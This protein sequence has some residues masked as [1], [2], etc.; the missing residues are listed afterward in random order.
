MSEVESFTQITTHSF[1]V[2]GDAATALSGISASLCIISDVS[3]TKFLFQKKDN[4]YPI[5]EIRGRISMFGG[6]PEKGE[7]LLRA[8][9]RELHEELGISSL[10]KLISSV[11]PW[12]CFPDLPIGIRPGTYSLMISLATLTDSDFKILAAEIKN[13]EVVREGTGVCLSREEVVT[14]SEL[15]D[16]WAFSQNLVVKK[17]ISEFLI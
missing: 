9:K 4:G 1:S 3:R 17:F 13:P 8:V 14:L 2:S 12:R 15:S 16:P 10:D 5:P 11:I 7:D 6:A